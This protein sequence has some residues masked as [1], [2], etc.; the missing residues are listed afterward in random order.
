MS[1]DPIL[2]DVENAIATI[3]INRPEA[4]NAL[5]VPT[6]RAMHGILDKVETDPGVRVVVFTGAG[7]A[8]IAGGDI[9][10]LNSR[11]GLA[12]YQEFAEEIH[13]LFRRIETFDKP[14]IGAVNGFALGG[15]TELLLALDIRI[16]SDKAKLGLPEITLGLFPG[17]GGTQ[18]IIRQLPLCRAKEIM[19]AGDMLTPEEAVA[20]GLANRVVPH[21]S[22]MDS[23]RETAARIA[24]K[25]PLVL[26]LL[27]R[28]LVDGGDMPLSAALRHEQAMIGL[29]L[30]SADAHEGCSAFLEKR[31]ATFKG[32]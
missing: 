29:V 23:A 17:A 7:R 25:S 8:F 6:I 9:S 18:R 30:D 32:R 13:N 4:L 22:L 5:D 16:L 3:T 20:V 27:K 24:H 14:T 15:G 19:F 31:E 12:H 2:L 11:Q 1:T 28:T 10:D 26:K 21:D